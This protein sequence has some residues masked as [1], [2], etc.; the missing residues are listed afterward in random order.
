MQIYNISVSRY[1]ILFSSIQADKS[2]LDNY[3]AA[4]KDSF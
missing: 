3:S 2:V 1:G 4:L